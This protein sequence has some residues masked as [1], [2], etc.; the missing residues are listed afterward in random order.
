MEGTTPRVCPRGQLNCSTFKQRT[1]LSRACAP[2]GELQR[3]PGVSSRLARRRITWSRAEQARIDQSCWAGNRIARFREGRFTRRRTRLW[4]GGHPGLRPRIRFPHR[5]NHRFSRG[6]GIFGMHAVLSEKVM[7]ASEESIATGVPEKA[8]AE[9]AER[10][11]LE[12]SSMFS[13]RPRGDA[14]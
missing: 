14:G 7:N 8:V 13:G 10:S 5:R 2:D 6:I 3:S 9:L 4:L 1:E 11:R 12:I